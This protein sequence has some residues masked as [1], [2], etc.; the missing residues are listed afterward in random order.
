MLSERIM[1]NPFYLIGFAIMV[2]VLFT[3]INPVLR[4]T[5]RSKTF[6]QT[7]GTPESP[8]DRHAQTRK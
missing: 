6:T 3:S 7:A 1:V 2:V 4:R 8:R 5:P